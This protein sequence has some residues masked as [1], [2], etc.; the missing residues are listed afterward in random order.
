MKVWRLPP[1]GGVVDGVVETTGDDTTDVAVV[2]VVA[3]GVET[4]DVTT[5]VE[6]PDAAGGLALVKGVL[7]FAPPSVAVN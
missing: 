2:A 3:G 1:A 5:D 7:A 4:R 6:A